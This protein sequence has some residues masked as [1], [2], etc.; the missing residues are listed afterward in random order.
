MNWGSLAASILP[1]IGDIVGSLIGVTCIEDGVLYYA[2]KGLDG[3]D[4]EFASLFYLDEGQYCLYNQSPKTSDVVAM[5]FPTVGQRGGETLLVP[6]R[7]SWDV[8]AMFQKHAQL[9]DCDFEL[10]ACS[11]SQKANAQGQG[12]VQISTS[13]YEVPLNAK[14]ALGSYMDITVQSQQ[15]L[16]TPKQGC[17]IQSLPLL[18][19]QGSGDTGIRVVD[20]PAQNGE[21][22]VQLPQP[23]QSGTL[24]T[25]EIMA[26]MS[27]QSTQKMLQAQVTRAKQVAMSDA[28]A[29]RLKSAPRLNWR[30]K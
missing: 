23:L 15:V 10:S 13:A 18:Y 28:L 29:G 2:H 17:Q 27:Q 25:A 6:G 14:R 4:P 11:I 26:S 7:Q 20:A 9:E 12:G 8:T 24:V 22:T 16:V 19:I 30:G 5:S 3:A 1:T 21:V